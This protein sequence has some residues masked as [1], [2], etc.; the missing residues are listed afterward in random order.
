M[1]ASVPAALAL[2]LVVLDAV[3][4]D[5]VLRSFTKQRLSEYFWSEGASYGDFNRDGKMDVVA[6]PYWYEG[7]DFSQRHE[8]YPA[9]QTFQRDGK[10]IP[11]FQG[12]LGVKNVYS[13]NFFAF[14]RDFNDDGWAD[15]LIYG[16]PG[17]DASWF[18][19]PQGRADAWKRHQIFDTV[20][21]ESPTFAD[22]DGDGKSEI[23][24]N[25][26]GFFGYAK[27]ESAD[28]A[29]PWKFH[30]IS[31]KGSW[32]KFNHGLG[33]GDVNGDGRVD[34]I[35]AGGWWEQ[36]ASLA[37]EPVWPL[38]RAEFGKGAQFYAYDVNGDG[39]NDVIGSLA[40]HGYGLAWHEQMPDGTFRRQLILGDKPE[41]N[42]YGVVF[43][44]LHAV[45]LADIDGD[46]LKDIVTGKRFWAHGN[47][48][49]PEPDAPAV[50]YWFQLV[51]GEKGVDFVPHRIDDDSGVGTQVV[52]GDVNA[53]GLP[54]VLVGNKKGA[55]VHLQTRQTVTAEEWEKRQPKPN[56]TFVAST[57]TPATRTVVV[58]ASSAAPN[59]PS[60]VLPLGKDGKPLNLDFEDGT[61]RDWT[62]AGEAF[63]G[64]PV[65]GPID[66]TR[67]YG[68]GK[69]AK[70]QGDYWIGGF[71]L[72]RDKPVGTLT[73]APFQ[74]TH[75]FA[76]FRLGGGSTNG[77]RVELVRA[78]TGEVFFKASGRNSET[79]LPVVVDLAAQKDRE[80]FIR[81]VDE[82][83][84]GW[85]HLNF[86]D[87]RF[88]EKKPD[89]AAPIP[90]TTKAPSPAP[91]SDAFKFAGLTPEQA[92]KEMTLPPGF[93]ATL[94]AGEPDV[95][96]PIAFAL[97][98]RG[99]LWVAE[100]YAYPVRQPE[101]QGKD[102]IL[103]F[104][105][106]DGDGRFDRRTVFMEGL[107]LVSGIEVGFGGVWIGTAPTLTFIPMQD[108][109]EPK[110]A[111]PPQ[112]LLDGWG[113][114]DTHETLNTFRWG[115]D[116]W[117]Y[118]CHGVFT[119]SAVGVPGTPDEARTKINAGIWRFHPTKKKF[120]VFAEGTS[121]PWGLDFND[122]GHAIIEACVIPHLWHVIQG[123]HYHRQAGQ[124][125]D[126]N[127]YD[128]IKTI[129][130]H[131]HYLGDRPHAGNNYSDSVGGGHAHSGLMIYLGDTWPQ[132]YRGAAFMNN[133][134]GARINMDLLE[135]RGSGY[136]G[137]HGEDFIRFNDAWSQIVDLQMGPDDSAYLIDWYDKQQ[138]HNRNVEVH[139]RSNGRIFKVS[140]GERKTAPVD[141]QK[142]SSA[143]LV[144]LQLSPNEWLV[145]HARRILQER[146]PNEEVHAA[147]G[148]MFGENSDPKRQLR[149]LW[150]LHVTG[151]CT[152]S[153][154]GKA[155]QVK[156]E[157]V[158]AWTIQLFCE[159]AEKRTT[160]GSPGVAD[161]HGRAARGA[162][163]VARL[164]AMAKNDPS[165]TVRLYLASAAQR[166]DPA[167]RWEI[168]AGLHG[169]AEDA[170]DHNLPL[171]AWYALEPL[172]PLDPAR[173]LAIGLDSKLT[174][175][176]EFTARRIATLGTPEAMGLLA[177]ALEK[178][179]DS[180]RQLALL[181]GVSTALKGQRT[182]PTPPG[183]DRVETKLA[184]AD[185]KVRALAQSL[186][187]TFG[188]S[189]ALD[190][191]RK[192]L[193]DP[194]ASVAARRGTLAALLNVQDP[195]LAPIL[196]RLL[197]EPA[198]RAEALRGLAAYAEPQ[199]PEAILV[200]YPQ[201]SAAE[202]RDA[203]LT[204][205]SRG[206]FAG[207]LLAAIGD[208]RV[209][210]RDLSA[211]IARQIRGFNDPSLN[212]QLEKL[213]GVAREGTADK[214]AAREK[215]KALIE[216]K[217][218]VKA[219]A[220]NGRAIF[221]RTCAACHTLFGAGG[222][223]GPDLTGSNRADIDY[224]LHNILDPNAEIPNAYRTST[225]ELKDGRFLVGV[226]NQQ[227]PKVVTVVT[228]NETLTVPR[229]EI[230]SAIA[231]EFSMMPEGLLTPL[232]DREV[233]DLVAYLRSATQIPLPTTAK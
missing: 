182:V 171:M 190:A 215:Y 230:K 212:A 216:S 88:H 186:S 59:L 122:Y 222:K 15:I 118:G 138:C 152:E 183:W 229:S 12:A 106:K 73:S 139:D 90:A 210:A 135:P 191:S 201:L 199:T 52:V 219:D 151:G 166:I 99:R 25:S 176:T 92:A 23:V 124:H 110:P 165:P 4:A 43:S 2:S 127:V 35:E 232:S 150:T 164:A 42:R 129:A 218:L 47:H 10:T 231:S 154:L 117:L 227:D 39:R 78:D 223:I 188:S 80:I 46:G 89:L 180:A 178:S 33:V 225:I 62:A 144:K 202:K 50:V 9:T 5:Q 179:D 196:I 58:P 172:V 21:N 195:A 41:Q 96:Q 123:A 31:P 208:D 66:E 189:R 84:P 75:P 77:E 206:A 193:A 38:H 168:V 153:I 36:P 157:Y 97:D 102:R 79:M 185:P 81:L 70:Q 44:Q 67:P 134:H 17:K 71:E 7:P 158:R 54:D 200:L 143:E 198:L 140:Y 60:G 49:D 107:N 91:A 22:L 18:E 214:I 114:G 111:G 108:G 205:A 163:P 136:V 119:H 194:S 86:D 53:D 221:D 101:G 103:V 203:L 125:F 24:C 19:N 161:G 192:L 94:F 27:Q 3:A 63:Q 120:E 142:L 220:A 146:G 93:R 156:D 76:T 155:L 167:Q 100:A 45:E 57:A 85:G 34:L 14:V 173:A 148:K 132:E 55:F 170:Q 147:L 83:S 28:P 233:R 204:L 130:D 56:P 82:L 213:W 115:P 13:D 228:P 177:A 209:P 104:E 48:G 6:G 74:V 68:K 72:L 131:F 128:D 113:Y 145:R 112:V 149:A 40:A 224:L 61:L 105:D 169:H 87:F 65:K 141:L 181:T 11:G 98:D 187:L 175:G 32:A 137:K 109:D 126:P 121:N 37:G 69:V 51:R 26:G 159:D 8:Y 29:Q 197:A 162:L 184:S 16:F 30:A 211:D 1:K 160:G 226:A 20:D 207:P 217:A 133:I 174:R 64:Q 116:G 95:Q